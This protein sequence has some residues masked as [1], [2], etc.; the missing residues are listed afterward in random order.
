[1]IQRAP[2][3]M[4]QE[5]HLAEVGLIVEE[6]RKARTQRTV[7]RRAAQAAMDAR[8][9]DAHRFA[10]AFERRQ[11]QAAAEGLRAARLSLDF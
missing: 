4:E 9:I 5:L 6:H 11:T 2:L 1:M 10:D 3:S 8:T 7:E